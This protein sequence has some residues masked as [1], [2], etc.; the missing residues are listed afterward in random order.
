MAL[1]VE[2]FFAERE[3]IITVQKIPSLTGFKRAQ[4]VH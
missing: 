1:D 2:F 4:F 3:I